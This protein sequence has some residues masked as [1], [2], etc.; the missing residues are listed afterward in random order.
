[1]LR[2]RTASMKSSGSIA[3]ARSRRPA[4]NPTCASPYW[5]MLSSSF[6]RMPLPR[7]PT[8]KTGSAN[9]RS[10]GALTSSARSLPPTVATTVPYS[11]PWP[12]A[13]P[14]SRISTPDRAACAPAHRTVFSV[15]V[16][17]MHTTSAGRRAARIP[18]PAASAT[19]TCSSSKTTT[20]VPPPPRPPGQHWTTSPSR[21][22]WRASPGHDRTRLHGDQPPPARARREPQCCPAPQPRQ[23]VRRA[24]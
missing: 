3:A 24:A 11:K 21:R 1:M 13:I 20:E 19:R 6:A 9:A 22:T 4:S 16:L 23:A 5:T 12:T 18:S 8:C 7:G 17:R 14:Q 2:A 10:T 15:T